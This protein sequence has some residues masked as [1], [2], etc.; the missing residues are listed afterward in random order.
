MKHTIMQAFL[1][2]TAHDSGFDLEPEERDGWLI[3]RSS[4][5]PLVIWLNALANGS[6]A[7]AVSDLAI[8]TS[9]SEIGLNSDLGIPTGARKVLVAQNINVLFSMLKRSFQLSRS[10]PSAPLEEFEKKTSGLPNSTE[11]ER[12]VIQR[13]GQNIFRDR[14]MDYWDSRC[15]ITGLAIPTL[16]RASHIKPW[17]KC[18][19]D[20]E[21]LDVFNGI[22]LAPHL[23]ALFDKGFISFSDNSSILISSKIGIDDLKALGVSSDMKC[24]GITENHKK[25]LS[26]HRA[27]EFQG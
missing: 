22:L 27:N 16:L 18:I 20:A 11:I 7:L 21:R 9:L 19:S 26:W 4:H 8:G 14:L 6:F 2:K 10:L 24:L 5:C 23:D 12:S 3:V 15:P 25:Y 17:S 13:V 1:E